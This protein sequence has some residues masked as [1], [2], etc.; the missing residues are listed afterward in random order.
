MPC[1]PLLACRLCCIRQAA[2]HVWTTETWYISVKV[3][4]Y[5]GTKSLLGKISLLFLEGLTKRFGITV[6]L[7]HLDTYSGKKGETVL[8]NPIEPTLWIV[9]DVTHKEEFVSCYVC[10]FSGLEK[11][12]CSKA[13]DQELSEQ[14]T[15]WQRL[16]KGYDGS[17]LEDFLG[18]H[19][20]THIPT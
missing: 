7:S 19:T 11:V 1:V 14:S 12:R 20:R 4:I 16:G 10:L 2:F 17:A 3:V 18:G 9:C 8:W 6:P 13:E 15:E 5:S